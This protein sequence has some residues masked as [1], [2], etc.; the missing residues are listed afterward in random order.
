LRKLHPY[1]LP[2]LIAVP[3]TAGLPQYLEW[4][5]QETTLKKEK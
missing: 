5:A 1:E 2:E 4:V 3:V